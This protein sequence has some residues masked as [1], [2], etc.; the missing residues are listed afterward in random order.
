MQSDSASASS[1]ARGSPPPT[2]PRPAGG[3]RPRA[4]LPVAHDRE[5]DGRPELARAGHRAQEDVDAL[6]RREPADEGRENLAGPDAGLV[7]EG[8]ARLGR[9][10]EEA[11]ELQAERDDLEL[12]AVGDPEANEVV[13]GRGAHAEE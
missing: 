1:S 7:P 10:P 5:P 11:V 2:T 8:A 9:Q 3:P 6:D 12:R 4:R 13:D